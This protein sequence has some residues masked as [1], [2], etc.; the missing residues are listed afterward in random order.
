M[1][2]RIAKA[3][4]ARGI[5][6]AEQ[7][8]FRDAFAMLDLDRSLTLESEELR[9]ALDAI[10]KCPTDAEMTQLFVDADQSETGHVDL[11]DFVVFMHNASQVQGGFSDAH[12]KLKAKQAKEAGKLGG[13]GAVME[14]PKPGKGFPKLVL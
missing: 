9:T 13:G 6:R 8:S 1:E 4:V 2:A 11:A 14:M 5:T 3:C 7:R 12:V 10:G